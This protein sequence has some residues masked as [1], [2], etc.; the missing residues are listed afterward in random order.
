MG[1]SSLHETVVLTLHWTCADLMNEWLYVVAHQPANLL[2]TV[3]YLF[4]LAHFTCFPSLA[5]LGYWL[6]LCLEGRYSRA[7]SLLKMSLVFWGYCLIKLPAKD[8]RACFFSLNLESLTFS[9]TCTVLHWA[10][11]L[12]SG[13]RGWEEE[14]PN[15]GV[16]HNE[17]PLRRMISLPRSW[18]SS[19]WKRMV[20]CY[21]HACIWFDWSI[22][23]KW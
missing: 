4:P 14:K 12:L 10:L 18:W 23:G 9:S 7:S 1:T 20:P 11:S 13:W 21:W 8:L 22:F 19:A 15:Y 2:H 3:Q 16:T 6:K 17:L 5:C